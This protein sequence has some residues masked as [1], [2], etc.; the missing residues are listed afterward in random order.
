VRHLSVVVLPALAVAACTSSP[1]EDHREADVTEGDADLVIVIHA[2]EDASA[3]EAIDA[4]PPVSVRSLPRVKDEC[5]SEM[6]K[7]DAFCIDKYEAYVV[8]LDAKGH[9][10]PHSPYLPVDGLA[11]RAKVAPGVL[12]QGYISQIQ[13]ERACKH[14]GKRLCKADEFSRAC[15]GP[16][17]SV[18]YPYGGATYRSG[19][20]NEG[21]GSMVPRYYGP[22]P[23]KWSYAN[24]NDPR[25]NR[26]G[27]LAKTGSFKRC[28]SHEGVYD[29]VG[30]LHE[31]G[32]DP[33][34]ERGRGRFRGGWYGDAEV[35]GHGCNYVTKAHENWY[36]DYSTGF[37][38]C[39]DPQ[40][41]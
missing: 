14:A 11:V 22:N 3:D 39:M 4:G 26:E 24:F 32:A 19:V 41:P 16:D 30:N 12:P 15:R 40:Q 31:W 18:L 28:V 33:P 20:C 37:R 17:A 8:E 25:L 21:H 2:D 7:I 29:L 27:F 36:H 9:E 34:D 1:L 38:C 13:A 6:V 10:H 35:N 5:L 23:Y